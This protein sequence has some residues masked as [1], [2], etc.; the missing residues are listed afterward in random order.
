MTGEKLNG[1]IHWNHAAKIINN[2]LKNNAL[3]YV[4][5]WD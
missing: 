2:A 4:C 3:K 5:I 1:L